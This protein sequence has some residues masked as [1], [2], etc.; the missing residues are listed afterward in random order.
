ME[1]DNSNANTQEK[2]ILWKMTNLETVKTKTTMGFTLAFEDF[3]EANNAVKE[4]FT[5]MGL[6]R[7]HAI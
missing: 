1:D 5:C 6:Q 3:R 4:Q 7:K 2:C